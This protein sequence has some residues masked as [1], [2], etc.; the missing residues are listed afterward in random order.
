M[1]ND[2]KCR[3]LNWEINQSS[4]TPLIVEKQACENQCLAEFFGFSTAIGA[5]ATASS[6]PSLPYPRKG[7][8]AKKSTGATSPASKWM[9]KLRKKPLPGKGMPA[10]TLKNP[11][12]R[13]TSLGAG[14]ARWMGWIGAGMLV[15]NWRE[16]AICS[17]ECGKEYQ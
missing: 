7:F 14:V 9:R 4:L 12:S 15:W 11:M 8:D 1:L 5:V 16:L 17:W 3:L 6:V 13:T 10:P 2:I